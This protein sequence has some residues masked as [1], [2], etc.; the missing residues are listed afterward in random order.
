MKIIEMVLCGSINKKIV[1]YINSA[2]GSAIGLCGKDGN[3]IKAEKIAYTLK[4]NQLSNIAKI[5]DIGFIGRPA[6][7]NPDIL[8]FLEESDFIPIIAPVGYGNNRETYHMDAES[9]V[10]AIA[11]AVS[12]SKIIIFS[13][14]DKEM[15]K[16]TNKKI[17]IKSLNMSIDKKE[18]KEEKFL[19]TLI[20]CT[21]VVKECSGVAHIVNGK[22]PN[23]ILELFTENNSSV[24]IINDP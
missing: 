12:A 4:E 11:I 16:I 23:V 5:L 10:G 19:E 1:Q 9:V 2:G 7:V 6:E 13:D 3:L 15:D 21:R 20:M 22:I 17:S 14:S 24:S 18:I 8:F